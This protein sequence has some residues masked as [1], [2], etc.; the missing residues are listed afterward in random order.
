THS[1]VACRRGQSPVD[2]RPK[3]PWADAERPSLPSRTITDTCSPLGAIALIHR[4]VAVGPTQQ[5]ASRRIPCGASSYQRLS[6]PRRVR[7]EPSL[8]FL[9]A[10]LHRSR[11]QTSRDGPEPNRSAI[12]ANGKRTTVWSK[13]ELSLRTVLVGSQNAARMAGDGVPQQN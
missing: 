4:P 7:R 9:C 11:R 10:A 3:R 12:F 1:S 6:A 8:I 13:S 5:P 2:A